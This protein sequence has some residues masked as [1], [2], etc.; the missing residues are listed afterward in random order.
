ML[1]TRGNYRYSGSALRVTGTHGEFGVGQRV[2]WVVHLFLLSRSPS[3][4]VRS[5]LGRARTVA[6]YD[7]AFGSLT[8][9]PFA[10]P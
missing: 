9:I 5:H 2:L 1:A 10:H 7:A 6:L 3:T 8:R 4:E